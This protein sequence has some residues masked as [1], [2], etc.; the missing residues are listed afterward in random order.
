MAITARL[1]LQAS[2][3][4]PRARVMRYPTGTRLSLSLAVL[5][6]QC[7]DR[8]TRVQTLR[9]GPQA[10]PGARGVSSARQHPMLRQRV[11]VDHLAVLHQ[12]GQLAQVLDVGQR[13]GIEDQEIRALAGLE[14]AELRRAP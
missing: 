5:R 3:I 11:A 2:R 14:R 6:Y 4:S 12:R 9:N 13:I 1:M 8:A 10:V 7:G